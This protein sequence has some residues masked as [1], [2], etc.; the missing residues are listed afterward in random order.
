MPLDVPVLTGRSVQLEPLTEEHRESL[1]PAADDER[2]WA[3]TLTAAN[4][5]LFDAWFDDALAERDA[6]RRTPFA[7]RRLSDRR[8]LGSS[9]YLDIQLRHKRIEIG[10]TWYLPEVW[11]TVVNPECKL[12]LLRHA[13]E[14]LGVNRVALV[15]DAVNHRSQSA[16]ARLGAV[17][18]GVLRAHMMAQGERVRD[19]VV[20]SIL[21]AEWPRVRDGLLQ[22]LE[23]MPT[24]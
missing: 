22:R 16:I 15:T 11:S 14:V 21:A 19:T 1:R 18:E 24:E 12:L 7:V 8:I 23:N 2:I 13:F 10:S 17:R 5:P 9:S 3:H 20:F 6:G 4:G